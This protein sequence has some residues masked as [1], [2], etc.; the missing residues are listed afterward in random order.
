MPEFFV[1][2]IPATAGSKRAFPIKR[3][4]GKLGVAVTADC[5]RSKPWMASIAHEPASVFASPFA[6]GVAIELAMTF[7][8]PR[9]AGQFRRNGEL[10]K[11]APV[12]RV[13]LPDL[14]KLVRC[15]EDALKGIAWIDDSQVVRSRCEKLYGHDPGVQIDVRVLDNK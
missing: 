1:P 13:K 2:G 6:A 11:W 15:A 3:K 8:L 10:H 5:K 9:P 12:Y 7:Y 14:H 4:D